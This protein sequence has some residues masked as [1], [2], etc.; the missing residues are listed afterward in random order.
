MYRNYLGRR[1]KRRRV[2]ETRS[3]LPLTNRP[4]NT[5]QSPVLVPGTVLSSI[6][7]D[8]SS[9]S[10][11]PE[12]TSLN[13]ND[14]LDNSIMEKNVSIEE[15]LSSPTQLQVPS[16]EQCQKNI[17]T[18]NK[19]SSTDATSNHTEV[20]YVPEASTILPSAL[21]PTDYNV[22]YNCK[23]QNKSVSMEQDTFK[24]FPP[25]LTFVDDGNKT[26][27]DVD[28][29]PKENTHAQSRF[30][31][32]LRDKSLDLFKKNKYSSDRSAYNR[33]RR[34][35]KKLKDCIESLGC[36][37]KQAA[38]VEQTL[39]LP[40]MQKL[41]QMAHLVD[42]KEH[43]VMSN[44]TK[45]VFK[46]LKQVSDKQ[47][48]R[49]RLNNDQ[50][51]YQE[52]IITSIVSSPTC[53]PVE[54]SD[55]LQHLKKYMMEHSNITKSTARRILQKGTA[56]RAYLSSA[57]HDTTWCV[58]SNRPTYKTI[59][60]SLHKQVLEWILCH[61]HVIPSSIS[62]DTIL[63]YNPVSKKREPVTKLL[64]QISVRE[65]H[66][67]LIS[68]PPKGLS[69][70]Y[71][72]K[73]KKL[74]VSESTLR[75]MLPP[76]LRPMNSSQ[77][78]ICG[79]EC[80]ITTKMLHQALLQHRLSNRSLRSNVY[81]NKFLDATQSD[82]DTSTSFHSR[83]GDIVKLLTCAPCN[84]NQYMWKCLLDRCDK[85][86]L[87]NNNWYGVRNSILTGPHVAQ[88]IHFGIYKMQTRCKVHGTLK[89]GARLC[90]KCQ[91]TPSEKDGLI[92]SKKELTRMQL[93]LHEFLLDHYF[94][95]FH[96]FKYH[97]ALVQILGK[98]QTK[99]WRKKAFE[100]HHTWFLTERDYAE[101]LKK[102]LDNEI[103]SEHFG[104]HVSLSIEGCTME[105]HA[106]NRCADKKSIQMDFHSHMADESDQDAATTHEHMSRMLD[107]YI[108]EYG[109]LPDNCVML[110]HTDGCAKQYR[111]GNAL[112][113]LSVLANK[114]KIVIDRAIAAPGHGKS[115]IDGLNAVD[116]THLK[117]T[118][119]ISNPFMMECNSRRMDAFNF[120]NQ[121]SN[122]F[123]E[124]CARICR[125]KNR[126]NGVMTGSNYKARSQG[127][128]LAKRFYHIHNKNKTIM[129]IGT[130][131]SD[132]SESRI[133]RQ[134]LKI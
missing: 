52:S 49:G 21:M 127:A 99:F 53:D 44:V 79:C 62:K 93:P 6:Q 113:Y 123:A 71:D 2:S 66:D 110:D 59:Q 30:K 65:L 48:S 13:E 29:N 41:K 122:S 22:P 31:H 83:P 34:L 120:T 102:E 85:C 87:K 8:N 124:E 128:K 43:S 133:L 130:K 54:S 108:K 105:H 129:S 74:L 26:S 47:P 36:I 131:I 76:Q 10:S 12:S 35:I 9:L 96:K 4:S 91:E 72:T 57:E 16:N 95:Q 27:F 33:K 50:R 94:P 56:R 24:D 5:Q 111:C 39:N 32:R 116:K 134:C 101:R 92:I 126:I 42:E 86:N 15:C 40:D 103:Q 104:H 67:D 1:P 77:K 25:L 106:H 100:N 82:A 60:R 75:T 80:C 69:S 78:T 38:I 17:S 112:F 63:V 20:Q 97:I 3:A 70:V 88:D 98:Y 84:D 81:L 125:A 114:Y 64:L 51:I 132:A 107:T 7:N 68:S 109:P 115:I 119:M 118:M 73:T 46:S 19:Y 117:Q 58:L 55:S 61:E 28:I 23:T 18:E 37:Q 45:N 89:P 121:K 14:I 11:L 90:P